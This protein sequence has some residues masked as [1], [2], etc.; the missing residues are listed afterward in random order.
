V[1]ILIA[2]DH[3]FVRQGV[4]T[5]LQSRQGWT[6]C[7]EAVDGRDA[8]EK[9]EQL[10]PD[11]VVMDVSMPNL[12]GLE[13]TREV[14]RMLPKTAVLVLSQHDSPEMMKEALNAGAQG[15]VVKSSAS[16]HL[17]A[18]LEKVS[19][20]DASNEIASATDHN[21]VNAASSVEQALRESEERFQGAMNSIA[22]GV[23][24]L[25][26]NG[27]VTY[28]NPSAE[29]ILGWTRPELQGKKIHDIVHYKYPDGRPFPASDCASWQVLQKGTELREHEDVLIRKDGGFFPVV[30]SSSP[31]KIGGAITGIV[32]CFRDDTRRR[33]AE[34]SL[35]D[36]ATQL[37][38]VSDTI[39]TGVIRCSRDLRYLW[40]NARYA[41]WIG[42]PA[43]EIV[44]HTITEILGEKA[45]EELRPYFDRVLE[46]HPVTFEQ[47]IDFKK[48]GR[49]W[50]LASY[51]PT[52]DSSGTADGWVTSVVDVTEQKQR[53]AERI[54]QAGLL[55][56]S[57]NAVIL[58]DMEDRITYWN[59]GAEE[60]YGWTR[61][62]ALGQV[63][64]ALFQT[65]FSESLALI[66]DRFLRQGRWQGEVLHTCKDGRLVTVLSRWALTRDPDTN[67]GLIME[68]NIN[69]TPTKEAE[70]QLQILVQTLETRI[71]DRT[72]ELQ[73]A[74]EKL[75]ELSGKLL[76]TQDEERRRIARELHDGVGQ[77]LAAMNMN[78]SNL[79]NEL[80]GVGEEAFRYVD[81]NVALVEQASQEIRTISHL[82]HPPLLDVM[83][84][85]SALRW[86]VDGYSKRSKITVE[87]ELTPG[88]SDGL[89]RDFALSLF[90]IV[91]E[92]LTNIHRHSE[93]ASAH[94]VVQR[95]PG[96]ITLGI[97]DDGK[98]IPLEIQS[99]ISS[100]ASS[101]VGLRGIRERIRQ[102][103]GRLEV[104]SGEG[105]TQI[106]ATLPLPKRGSPEL[107]TVEEKASG[108]LLDDN[109]VQS[110][111]KTATILCIDDE[112]AGLLPRKL[113][114]ESAGYRVIEARSGEEGIQL[115][116]SEKIDAVILDYWMSGMKGTAVATE[117]K[118]M[119]PAV[120]IIVLSGMSD[121]PGEAAGIVDHWFVK[122]SNRPEHL[123]NSISSLLE[124]RLV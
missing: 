63:T 61:E 76:R 41:E 96:E 5:L 75:R 6:V 99:K 80:D 38:L 111:H 91:Q 8:I 22:E 78:F 114:L 7:G 29:A 102:F 11:V 48:M 64:H 100:G 59:K 56:L 116:Q 115:F 39:G 10:K 58:R 3:E 43:T 112:P 86:Y 9:A 72:Q 88:F 107:E 34:K 52:F 92:C 50:I 73:E 65:K 122:G 23:Y 90:R 124:R 54:K 104:H 98:G 67:S 62:Q 28:I 70:K 69:I 94:I 68:A 121:L 71:A 57:F 95:S 118:R 105:G 24:T 12:N 35:R 74:T 25:D 30:L 47:Q 20:P 14:R 117:L 15:Y 51:T 103:G 123:L 109:A 53:D 21:S 46:G 101:G 4:R 55:D 26:T 87:M 49:R 17:I 81:E 66:R 119:K 83:G 85:E 37:Q 45:F 113:L 84:L 36:A 27:L 82:L 33:H 108:T 31:L 40:V 110:G 60:L 19:R 44:D 13:A 77:L 32:V 79:K 1:R 16:E 18:A 42:R 2:D 120:P 97:N 106:I 93:S 89:P